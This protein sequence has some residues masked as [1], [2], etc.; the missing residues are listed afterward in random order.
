MLLAKNKENTFMIEVTQKKL[1]NTLLDIGEAMLDSGA[2]VL[3]V[4]DTINR[5]GYA[6]Q[7]KRMDVFAITS[8]IN[9]SMEFEDGS[10]LTQVRRF[11]K[12]NG[13]DLKK[14]EAINALSRDVCNNLLSTDELA[15]RVEEIIQK[16]KKKIKMFAGYIL[17]AS[18]FAIFFGGNIYD[19]IAA[20]IVGALVCAL[21]IFISP[22]FLNEVI[23]Q[24]I[25]SFVTGFSVAFISTVLPGLNQA[26]IMIGVIMLLVPGVAFTNS[27]RDIL[28]GDTLSGIL[29]MIEALLLAGTLAIGI[30]VSFWLCARCFS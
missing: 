4:E 12:M 19:G 8:C 10:S 6:Y 13:T 25:I 2:E 29:R 18:A 20:G 16:R 15:H 24:G 30:I 14:L 7:V 28:L 11:R 22:F 9:I 23:S 27:L 3:R 17:A 26:E 21:Q 1:I 5:I